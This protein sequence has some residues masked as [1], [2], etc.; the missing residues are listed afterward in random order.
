MNLAWIFLGFTTVATPNAY[1]V[2]SF[3]TP[4]RCI[5]YLKTKG[6]AGQGV[7]LETSNFYANNQSFA[8]QIDTIFSV[9]NPPQQAQLQQLR[10]NYARC[11]TNKKETKQSGAITNADLW[12]EPCNTVVTNYN[13]SILNPR[14]DDK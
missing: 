14:F 10:D 4:E 12:P 3:S 9:V 1:E 11:Q 2:A 13:A 7:C 8:L 6:V 5:N